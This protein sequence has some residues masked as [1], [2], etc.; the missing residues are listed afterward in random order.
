MFLNK[1]HINQSK[2]CY[3]HFKPKTNSNNNYEQQENLILAINNHKIKK[4]SNAK[5]L[6]VHIDE[7][8]NWDYHIKECKRKLNY[9]IATLSRIKNVFQKASTKISIIPFLSL[10]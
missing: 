1:L 8:L 2:C 6:G 9:A 10:T 5:F 4:V 7:N 3:I